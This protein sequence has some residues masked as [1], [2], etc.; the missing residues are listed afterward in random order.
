M[1][2]NSAIAKFL[3]EHGANF[4]AQ[5]TEG[6][7]PRDVASTGEVRGLFDSIFMTK[8][9]EVAFWKRSFEKE[10]T[11][12]LKLLNSMNSI[13]ME[14][15]ANKGDMVELDKKHAAQLEQYQRD[16]MEQIEQQQQRFQE[17]LAKRLQQEEEDRQQ[18][19]QKHQKQLNEMKQDINKLNEEIEKLKKERDAAEEAHIKL[20]QQLHETLYP[21][22]EPSQAASFLPVLQ[23]TQQQQQQ[24]A[25]YV[26]SQKAAAAATV[27]MGLFV[28]GVRTPPSTPP[29][30]FGESGSSSGAVTP[31]SPTGRA[32]TPSRKKSSVNTE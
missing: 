32:S 18:E 30:G 31:S 23:Q 1:N 27:N 19:R 9:R 29:K 8:V 4:Y 3:M 5:T 10:Q 20:S 6:K 11:E 26:S 14:L 25:L 12:S 24:Q 2:G 13:F 15:K 28:K 16:H 22:H 17:E 21:R 7:I